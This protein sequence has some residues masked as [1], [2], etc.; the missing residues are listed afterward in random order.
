MKPC[1]W[2]LAVVGLMVSPHLFGASGSLDPTFGTGGKV[3]TDFSAGEDAAR[4]VVVQPDGKIVVAG[5]TSGDFALARYNSN[6]TLDSTFG[7]GGKVTTD[8]AGGQD[9]AGGLALQPDGKIVV[10]GGAAS[11]LHS[12]FAIARYNANGTLDATFGNGGKVTTDFSGSEDVAFGVVIQT[13]GKIVAAGAASHVVAGAVNTDFGLA[14]YNTD[15]TLDT[16]FGNGGQVTTDFSGSFDEAEAIALQLDGRVVLAGRTRTQTSTSSNDDFALSRYNTDGSLDTSF[17][18]AGKVMTDFTGI[19]GFDEAHALAIQSDGKIVAVGLAMTSTSKDDFA[20]ARYNTNG[21]LDATFGSG[22]KVITDFSGADVNAQAV[23][24]LLD[25]TILI[26]GGGVTTMTSVDFWLSRYKTNGTLDTGFGT[27][28]RVT[29]DFSGQAD[30]AFGLAIQSDGKIVAAGA[31]DLG[32]ARPTDFAL[33]R[34]E[35]LT[36]QDVIATVGDQVQDLVN[37]GALN[38]GQ[39]NS[40]TVKL[41]NI[42]NSLNQG[43]TKNA[44]N[45][46]DAFINEVNAQVSSG[47]LT[48]AQGQALLNVATSLKQMLGC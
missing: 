48:A 27:A 6:G 25:G 26:A 16:G 46:L 15:G 29:T 28:G 41:T 17:G 18:T 33:A 7:T 44:C 12:D 2:L 9:G 20:L 42:L 34:Y 1:T 10:A 37:S 31:A 43:K 47:V 19:P 3:T 22:G 14:R 40:L 30:V 4:A 8:F 23:A 32:D 13:D 45:Q 39:G 24:I 5:R 21:V 11:G 36:S 38:Q 35:G